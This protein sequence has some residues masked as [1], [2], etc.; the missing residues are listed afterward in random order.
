MDANGQ[1][2]DDPNVV[3]SG[4][5]TLLPVGGLDH[6]H[7]GYGMAIL[8]EAQ[9]QAVPGYNRADE[10]KGTTIGIFLQ[11]IDPQAFGG[12]NAFTRQSQWLV[13]ACHANLP[14]PGGTKVRLP[15]EHALVRQRQAREQGACHWP[16]QPSMRWC[17]WR[18]QQAWRGRR[19]VRCEFNSGKGTRLLPKR[20]IWLSFFT[21]SN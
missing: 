11:V 3:I 20:L 5:G 6:G 8:A 18:Q 15:G 14:L 10:P 12:L 19:V 9:T 13:D 21:I 16:C 1:P 7:K 2:S 4:G 17:R